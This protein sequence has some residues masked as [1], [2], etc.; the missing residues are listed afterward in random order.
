MSLASLSLILQVLL[1]SLLGQTMPPSAPPPRNIVIERPAPADKMS[2]AVIPLKALTWKDVEPFLDGMLSED[3]KAGYISQRHALIVHDRQGNIDEIRE[4]ISQVDSDPVNIRVE[5]EFLSDLLAEG[6]EVGVTFDEERRSPTIT[7][8][9]GKVK[10]PGSVGITANDRR[11]EQTRNTSMQLL[12]RSGYPARLWVGETI[13]D[14]NWLK[15]YELVPLTAV[16]LPGS[17]LTIRQE[18]P[19]LIWRDV[20][21]A[22]YILPTYLENGL[23]RMELF[24]VVTYHDREGKEH[25]FRVQQVETQVTAQDGQRVYLGGQDEV[26]RDFLRELLGPDLYKESSSSQILSMYVTPHV[27]IMSRPEPA[28]RR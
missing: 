22:L 13:V 16:L 24:P 14:P 19:D 9:D 12:T 10:G 23:V 20:G 25:R 8:E 28:N 26:T 6:R 17:K 18:V 4:F 27:R 1:P 15:R 5:V 11:R 3:G 7:I 2:S 21:S